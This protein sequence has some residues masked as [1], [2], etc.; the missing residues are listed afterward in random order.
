MTE[1]AVNKAGY[2][3]MRNQAIPQKGSRYFQ[4]QT[5]DMKNLT[6]TE[7]LG[8]RPGKFNIGLKGD[9]NVA[10]FNKHVLSVKEVDPHSFVNKND[11]LMWCRRNKFHAALGMIGIAIDVGRITISLYEEGGFGPKTQLNVGEIIG[12]SVGAEA[13]VAIG[14]AVGSALG[15]VIPVIGTT[16][17]GF[18]G[19]FIGALFGKKIV[20]KMQFWF[21]GG[22]VDQE[23]DA[24]KSK[25]ND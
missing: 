17:I 12:G 10:K 24:E 11:A 21:C 6:N 18:I 22:P 25:N 7:Q 8:H 15:S 1:F 14:C 2:N 13:A 4:P 3:E 16:I 5:G 23:K 9:P 20:E 19:G